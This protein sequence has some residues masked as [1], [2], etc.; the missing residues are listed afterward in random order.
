MEKEEKRERME[1]KTPK[2]RN[3]EKQANNVSSEIATE[4]FSSTSKVNDQKL[5]QK[6]PCNVCNGN[7][8]FGSKASSKRELPSED[9][10]LQPRED[11]RFLPEI[12]QLFSKM[13]QF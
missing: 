13:S 3:G 5:S 10:K 9:Q 11:M 8:P 1:A 6:K 2:T 12:N 7:L 4:V